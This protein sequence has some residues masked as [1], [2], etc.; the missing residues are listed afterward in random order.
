M[1]IDL[2]ILDERM[3]SQ[4]PAYATGGSA[5]LDLRACI[6]EAITLKPGQTTLIPTGLS[7]HINN[8]NYAAVILPRSGLG[9][10]HGI[11]LGNLVG[12]IDSDYQGQLMVSTWNR[13]QADFVISP[14]ERIAQLVIVPVQ[15]VEFNIV[16]EFENSDRG[17]DGFGSTGRH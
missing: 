13:G 2:K 7:I 10:K 16:D 3:R 4:L 15:Q 6:D 8:P 17:A 5:G 9:H 12:L 11:V 1:K 14:M